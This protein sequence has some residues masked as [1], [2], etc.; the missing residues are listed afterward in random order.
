MGQVEG[1]EKIKNRGTG[2]LVKKNQKRINSLSSFLF[3]SPPC[4][5]SSSAGKGGQRGRKRDRARGSLPTAV[6]KK[7][8]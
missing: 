1:E 5:V 8:K 7:P 2:R 3:F 4:E 6:G